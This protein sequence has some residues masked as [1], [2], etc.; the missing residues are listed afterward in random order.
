MGRESIKSEKVTLHTRIKDTIQNTLSD[1][2]V[3]LNSFILSPTPHSSLVENY[4]PVSD[5]NS[6]NVLFMDD[7]SY[8][9]TI[10][11]LLK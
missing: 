1:P 10:F 7:N 9:S 6:E 4:I 8:I 3:V 2:N 5:W 11:S